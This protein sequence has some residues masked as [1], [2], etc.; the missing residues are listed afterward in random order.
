M[1]SKIG[2]WKVKSMLGG[3]VLYAASSN[4]MITNSMYKKKSALSCVTRKVEEKKGL[5]PGLFG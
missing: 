5:A 3:G 1:A 2:F 4:G